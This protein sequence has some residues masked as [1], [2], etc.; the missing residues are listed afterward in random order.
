[1]SS[2]G[3]N[4]ALNNHSEEA[5]HLPINEILITKNDFN[6]IANIIN[7][8]D[9]V[10]YK[11]ETNNRGQLEKKLIFSTNTNRNFGYKLIEVDLSNGYEMSIKDLCKYNKKRFVTSVDAVNTAPT[12]TPNKRMSS[13]SNNNISNSNNNIKQYSSKKALKI[14]TFTM[15]NG[16]IDGTR[17]HGMPEPQSGVLTNFTTTAIA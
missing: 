12:Q 13:T 17:T 7:N 4:H 8:Y 2:S 10:E 15:L 1:M 11:Q 3:V 5:R 16:A 14:R 9:K 6:Y